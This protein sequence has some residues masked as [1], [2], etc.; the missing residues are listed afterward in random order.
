MTHYVRR[1]VDSV[2]E[3]YRDIRKQLHEDITVPEE[4]ES[5]IAAILTLAIQV[6]DLRLEAQK[7]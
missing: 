4:Q 1:S 7:I 5:L 3:D 2:M 6:E